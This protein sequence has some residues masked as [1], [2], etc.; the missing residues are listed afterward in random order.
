MT[1]QSG[2]SEIVLTLK[3]VRYWKKWKQTLVQARKL[4]SSPGGLRSA[5][6]VR[7]DA[8][9]P[10][11]RPVFILGCPRSGTTF[12]GEI[13]EA[14]PSVTYY[15]E[16]PAMKYYSRLVYERKV[17]L[18]QTRR[19]Y[20]WGFRALLLSAP[21]K[22]SRI[23]EK[24]PTHTWIAE[25]LY[26]CFPDAL[27]IVISRDGRDVSVSLAE[28]PWH[29]RDSLPLGKRE[30]GGYIYGPYPHFY[31]EPARGTEFAETSDLHRCIWIWRR[32]AEETERLKAALPPEV[33][34]RLTYE[35]LIRQP[36]PTVVRLLSFL[37][38]TDAATKTLAM[39]AAARGHSSSI[40]RWKKVLQAEDLAVIDREA[41]E[42]MKK[43]GYE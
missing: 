13:L 37:Q 39:E 30:P 32:H 31:I 41:G 40:G 20:H 8:L 18:A 29:R 10:I 15:F 16:P 27:F 22:G 42:M 28:K 38:E 34:F 1:G 17:T 24:N 43:L 25:E 5:L 36:E 6:K 26:Q 23:I 11:R 33:Q 2:Q 4:V 7:L 21:G 14:L 12:L 3:G 19:F 35:E 9:K